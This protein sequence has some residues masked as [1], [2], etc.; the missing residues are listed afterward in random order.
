MAAFSLCDGPHVVC[1]ACFSLY[2]NKSTS[3]LSLYLSLNSFCN[4]I[5]RT[6]TSLD[7]ETRYCG[8]WLGL[9]PSHVGSS[10]K[11]GIG[12]I[13][14]PVQGFESQS[15]F[16]GFSWWPRR[17]GDKVREGLK[18]DLGPKEVPKEVYWGN[19]LLLSAHLWLAGQFW[20]LMH[21][22]QTEL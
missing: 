19:A 22:Q 14:V 7:P 21:V 9:S 1:G 6:L 2:L 11:L 8:F 13:Q 3:Y 15:V 17:D 16:N 20:I 10:P 4:E 18:S 5:S 12:W